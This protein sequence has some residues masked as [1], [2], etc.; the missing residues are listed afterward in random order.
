M[1]IKKHLVFSLLI[2]KKK[3]QIYFEICKLE[4]LGKHETGDMKR[5]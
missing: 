2:L 1:H 3:S 5:Q 4:M